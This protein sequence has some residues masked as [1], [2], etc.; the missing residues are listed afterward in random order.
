MKKFLV[1]LAV[2]GLMGGFAVPAQATKPPAQA[3]RFQKLQAPV[4]TT[5]EVRVTVRCLAERMHVDVDHALYIAQRESGFQRN[6]VSWTGCC[7]GVFQ[8]NT[9]YWA[10]RVSSHT[11]KLDKYGVRDR[12]WTSPR[13][14][15][16]VTFA[17]VK[18]HGWG[19]WGG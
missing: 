17:M 18:Q 11:D 6:A 12:K 2:V 10:D 13:A 15:A 5:Y 4:W 7:K 19:P 16:V 1:G 3:C 9:N 8:H 14:Q